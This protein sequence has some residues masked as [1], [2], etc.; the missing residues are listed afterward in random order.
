MFKEMIDANC[1]HVT[2]VGGSWDAFARWASTE[3]PACMQ[4]SKHPDGV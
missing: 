2:P 1:E 3:V 4:V